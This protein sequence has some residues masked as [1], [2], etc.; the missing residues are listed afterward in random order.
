[1]VDDEGP[2]RHGCKVYSTVSTFSGQQITLWNYS[3]NNTSMWHKY[4][5]GLCQ[6]TE[7]ERAKGPIIAPGC[8]HFIQ[9]DNPPFVAEQLVDL[10]K[11]V[12]DIQ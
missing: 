6:L 3:K 4:N 5:E 11:K 9:K 1:M 2:D 7:P 8:G 12:E 10:I